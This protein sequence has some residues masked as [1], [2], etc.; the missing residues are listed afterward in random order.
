MRPAHTS[1]PCDGLARESIRYEHWKSRVQMA[2]DLDQLVNVVTGYLAEWRPEDMRMMPR[3]ISVCALR[4]AEEIP[5]RAVIAAQ[6]ELK[7]D[8]ALPDASL[9]REMA[10]TL[11][12]AATRLRFLGALR[13][14]ESHR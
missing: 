3:E 12:A 1:P 11:T 9:L 4:G 6:A 7:T 13:K 14:R 10:L 2:T 5:L 8:P